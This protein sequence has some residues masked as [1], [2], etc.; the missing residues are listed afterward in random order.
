[1]KQ[2]QAGLVRHSLPLAVCVLVGCLLGFAIGVA[3]Q[4]VYSARTEVFVAGNAPAPT[5]SDVAIGGAYSRTQALNLAAVA[6]RE[7]VLTPAIAGL[8]LDE[9]PGDLRD[10]VRVSVPDETSIITIEAED[11]SA[12]DA[13]KIANAVAASLAATVDDL[14]ADLDGDAAF[15]RVEV[16]ERAVAPDQPAGGE[17]FNS[18]LL[19]T[20]GG[21][22]VGVAGSAARTITRRRVDTDAQ[23]AELLGAPV[24]GSVE[25]GSAPLLAGAAD[26]APVPRQYADGYADLRARTSFVLEEQAADS[27]VLA[28][29]VP[30]ER[31]AVVAVELAES[32]ASTGMRVQVVET[33]FTRAGLAAVLDL[34]IP[35]GLSDVLAGVASVE[36]ARQVV[37]RHGL[38]VLAAGT[39]IPSAE[40]LDGVRAEAVLA[41]ICAEADLTVLCAPALT[42]SSDAAVLARASR[43]LV[44]VVSRSHVAAADVERAALKVDEVVPVDGVV[45]AR[46]S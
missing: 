29:T 27:L 32:F 30:G 8:G 12:E 16:I 37:G 9:T 15:L 7:A 24:L 23:A 2:V 13:A 35:L 44:L 26:A 46:L 43:P 39:S 42:S 31:A 36:E 38:Q 33:D 20:L 34:P 1:L 28:P 5:V 40:P 45:M 25:V 6:T 17:P 22:A 4:P 19:G 11:E 18:A 41:E 3:G 10:R 14:T 21:L